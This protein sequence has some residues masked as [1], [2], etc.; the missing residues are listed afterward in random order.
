MARE[1]E[2]RRKIMEAEIKK[3]HQYPRWTAKS[4]VPPER[5]DKELHTWRSAGY[6]ARKMPVQRNNQIVAYKIEVED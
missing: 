3:I 2:R 1:Q 4:I 5:A 6:R